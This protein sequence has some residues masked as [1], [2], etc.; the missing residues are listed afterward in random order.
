[1]DKLFS[2]PITSKQ[3]QSSEL[4]RLDISNFGDAITYLK[5][6]PYGRNSHR[7]DYTLV[8]KEQKGTC[9]TKHAFLAA[10]AKENNIPDVK[11]FLGFYKMSEINTQ[12]VGIILDK[13]DL[14]YIPEAHCYLKINETIVDITK[15]STNK[16]SFS[17][18]IIYEEEIKPYQINHYKVKK[19]QSFLKKWLL[20]TSI[21][22]SFKDIW[23][24]REAC[25]ENLS[26]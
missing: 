11:L 7:G 25:I 23:K 21:P 26:Q 19:H 6:L 5:K 18:S 10:M 17:H 20:E 4:L 24:I 16:E 13:W 2:Y 8:L 15:E 22:Y 14:S 12:G 9:S 3:E 1:M